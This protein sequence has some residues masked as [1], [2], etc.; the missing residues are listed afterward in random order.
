[1]AGDLGARIR[2]ERGDTV[3]TSG[4]FTQVIGED[5]GGPDL[6]TILAEVKKTE[7]KQAKAGKLRVWVCSH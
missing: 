2:Y 7:S 3:M 6:L 4:I 1:M 5:C